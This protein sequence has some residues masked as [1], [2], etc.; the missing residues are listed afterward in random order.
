[1]TCRHCTCSVVGHEF[2]TGESIFVHT[3]NHDHDHLPEPDKRLNASNHIN[4]Q[5]EA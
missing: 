3:C 4:A 1:M 2:A 5:E